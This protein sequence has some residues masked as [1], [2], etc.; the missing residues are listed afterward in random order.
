MNFE[1]KKAQNA[2]FIK[3]SRR[4]S[5]AVLFLTWGMHAMAAPDDT[6]ITVASNVVVTL[7]VF[8]GRPNPAWTLADGMPAEL[9]HRL[10]GLDVSKAVP[11]DVEDLGYRAVSA[12][13]L[14]QTKGAVTVKAARGIVTLDRGGRRSHYVDAGRQFEL[15]LVNTGAAHLTPDIL[16]HVTGEI[17]KPR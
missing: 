9:L 4:V 1:F 16:R 5:L 12:E 13:F 7:D 2:G 15:W 10:Q 8:S 3:L 6:S 14:D 11:R 17:T